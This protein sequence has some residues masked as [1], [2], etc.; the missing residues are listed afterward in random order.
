MEF[1]TSSNGKIT[2][3]MPRILDQDHAIYSGEVNTFQQ[4]APDVP[5]CPGRDVAPYDGMLGSHVAKT[6][7]NELGSFSP[8]KS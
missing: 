4:T 6:T 5:V 1:M 2:M 7:N 3:W 8:T